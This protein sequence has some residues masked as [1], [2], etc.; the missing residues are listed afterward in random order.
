MKRRLEKRSADEK[1]RLVNEVVDIMASIKEEMLRE[2]E[3]F[4][5]NS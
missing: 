2:K 5:D 1:I 4:E 3:M